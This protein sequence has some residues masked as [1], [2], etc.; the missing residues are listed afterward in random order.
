M[1]GYAAIRQ[2]RE[3]RNSRLNPKIARRYQ[4]NGRQ[5]NSFPSELETR[6]LLSIRRRGEISLLPPRLLFGNNSFSAQRE[7]APSVR[8]RP[9]VRHLQSRRSERKSGNN[10]AAVK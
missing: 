5:L 6:F 8:F 4:I 7:S 2:L 10:D 9:G 3:K 1:H